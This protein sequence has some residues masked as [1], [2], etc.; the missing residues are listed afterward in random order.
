MAIE[1]GPGLESNA[2]LREGALVAISIRT[3]R[4]GFI[5]TKVLGLDAWPWRVSTDPSPADADVGG[6]AARGEAI[7][8]LPRPGEEQ[9]SPRASTKQ[10][11]IPTSENR[12]ASGLS[13]YLA[14]GLPGSQ[15]RG[16]LGP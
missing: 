15:R 9:I 10:L 2:A 4:D 8:P 11:L 5:V 14:I 16:M 13:G 6:L 7:R 12:H 3:S 1:K